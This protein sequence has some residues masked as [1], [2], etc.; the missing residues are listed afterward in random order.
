MTQEAES[1]HRA[2]LSIALLALDP[3]GLGG[4]VVRMRASPMRDAVLT[5]LQAIPL[6]LK[7]MPPNISDEQL[8]GS[9]DLS[10]TLSTSQIIV[11]KGFFYN[12]TAILLT[13]AERCPI[14]LA[15]KLSLE[16]DTTDKHCLIALDEGADPDE[17]CPPALADRLAFHISPQGRPTAPTPLVPAGTPALE[18]AGVSLGEDALEDLTQLAVQLGID[19][20]R[21]PL[22]ASRAA[23]A[24]AALFGRSV[25]AFEDVEAAAALVLAPRATQ[26]PQDEHDDTPDTPPP[27]EAE[28][29]GEDNDTDTQQE[30]PD[31]DMLIA[32][33]KAALPPD[34]LGSLV[35]AGTSRNA[36]G[37]GAGQKRKSNRRGRPLPSQPGRLDGANR[38]DLVA[39]LRAA[40]PWQPIRREQRPDVSGLHIRS[41]DIRIK[42]FQERS[43]RLL[44]FVVDA[45]GSAAVSR[46][47]EAKGAIELL[48]AQAYATRDHV[49]LIA[50]RGTEAEVLLPPN[51]S[52]V[53]TKKRLAALPGGGGTPLASGL[54]EARAMVDAGRSKGLTPSVILITDGR[55]NVALDGTPNRAQAR[56]DATRCATALTATNVPSLVIDMSN[57]PQAGLKDLAKTLQGDYIALPR[58]DA[59]KL[60]AAV[61]ASLDAR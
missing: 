21:A 8:Y 40:A 54:L 38:I 61:S 33:V 20:L 30:L 24:H 41:S 18:P 22:L 56:T 49:S 44:I 26:L 4:A 23:K 37:A 28:Q 13:M 12:S 15:A 35:P 10:A 1:W 55:A 47:G 9:I 19:S 53:Q 5:E 43:D 32:A 48:L 34:I 51:K 52:L 31:G 7:K 29:D 58:A 36:Q 50:F 11:L 3:V 16:L 17:G 42:R 45:S 60:S 59:H 46:L 27:P 14:A 6:P 2:R 25:A 39:T 57:R